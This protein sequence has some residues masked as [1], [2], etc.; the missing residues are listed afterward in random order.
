MGWFGGVGGRLSLVRVDDCE[1]VGYT[2]SAGM[3][4]VLGRDWFSG[5]WGRMMVC[6]W[7]L[8]C[9][10]LRRMMVYGWRLLGGYWCMVMN[11]GGRWKFMYD[12]QW[13]LLLVGIQ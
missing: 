13:W 12:G 10:F 7:R 11:M 3:L 5:L 2:G 4:V 6:G 9:D 1:C 8:L